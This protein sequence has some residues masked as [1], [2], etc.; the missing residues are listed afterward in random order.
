MCRVLRITP[1]R[2]T[3]AGDR[4]QAQPCGGA[5]RSS[6]SPGGRGGTLDHDSRERWRGSGSA[7]R[8]P[9]IW[10]DTAGGS[11]G[12]VL[13]IFYPPA[14]QPG[15]VSPQLEYCEFRVER[16]VECASLWTTGVVESHSRVVFFS[17]AGS[18]AGALWSVAG[19][20][21]E[22]AGGCALRRNPCHNVG[23][24]RVTQQSSRL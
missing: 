20:G 23:H 3:T 8:D 2:S 10:T 6:G 24:S 18:L 16:V 11:G 17:C 7:M 9:H 13:C 15:V 1:P 21:G 22:Y 5:G 14:L 4:S 12:G 19:G